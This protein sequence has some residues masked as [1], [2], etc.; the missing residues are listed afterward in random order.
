MRWA[1]AMFGAMR[2]TIMMAAMMFPGV[3]PVAVR[4][5][6]MISEHRPVGL[7]AFGAGYL[8]VWAAAGIPAWL[9][10]LA[11]GQLAHAGVLTAGGATIGLGGAR[12][13]PSPL[14]NHCLGQSRTPAALLLKSAS[15]VWPLHSLPVR[16][17][18]GYLYG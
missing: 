7:L 16:L 18:I 4:Y 2:W 17:H 11:I 1:K 6:R 12:Y 5:T 15:W 14:K 10:G 8:A 13:Q 3:L 9:F